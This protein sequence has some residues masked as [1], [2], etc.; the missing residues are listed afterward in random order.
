[1]KL[2]RILL[3]FPLAAFASCSSHPT[4]GMEFEPGMMRLSGDVGYA[5]NGT[6]LLDGSAAQ[7]GGAFGYFATA[8]LEAGLSG[9]LDSINVTGSDNNEYTG[10]NG[11]G[12]YYTSTYGSTRSY[13]ELSAGRGVFS[14][15]VGEENVIALVGSIGVMHF[16]HTNWA[17]ELELQKSQYLFPDT[18]GSDTGAWGGSVGLAWF[19]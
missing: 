12:R 9:D 18:S 19:F 1:M 2:T 11:F 10:L 14:N 3:L 13:V 17:I 15:N 4:Q 5:S 8:N 6:G 7:L 16:V